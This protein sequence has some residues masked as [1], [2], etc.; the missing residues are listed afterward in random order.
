V[1]P[2]GLCKIVISGTLPGGE[3]FAHSQGFDIQTEPVTQTV[4]NTF[5]QQAS[6]L[7]V[8]TFLTAAVTACYPTVTAWKQVRG[9]LYGSAGKSVLV[10]NANP[11]NVPGTNGGSPCPNQ[12]AHVLTTL[13]GVPGRSHRGRVYLPA[14][15]TSLLTAGQVT[16]ANNTT[17]VNA[18][19]AWLNAIRNSAT[20]PGF[21]VVAS[22]T[23]GAMFTMTQIAGNTR[24]DV[25]RRR[26]NKQ[27]ATATAVAVLS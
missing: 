17:I 14:P 15:G 16:T 7:W 25:Q 23:Q 12:V 3:V 5:T 4:L 18:Y 2:A 24:L 8:S 9:Y 1:L 20:A 10:A 21:G 26:A 13:T 6:D 27:A 11:I 22:S 19:A